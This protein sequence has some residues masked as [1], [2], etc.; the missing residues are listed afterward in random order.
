[1]PSTVRDLSELTTIDNADMFLVS[2]TSDVV[3][4]DKRISRL[5]LMGTDMVKRIGTLTTVGHLPQFHDDN[6]IKGSGIHYLDVARL[7]TAQSYTALATFSAG[8]KLG[9][10]PTTL[11]Y[12]EEGTW[13]PALQFGGA[14]N[15]LT[16]ASQGL[17][18]RFIRVNKMVT[19]WA[20]LRLSHVGS[21]V[22][23]ATVANL[24]FP[25]LNLFN[26]RPPATLAMGGMSFTG[27]I[28]AITVHN[29]TDLILQLITNGVAANLTNAAFTNSSVLYVNFCYETT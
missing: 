24:P 6:T 13:T 27:T 28:V 15:G 9:A 22:G 14:S 26:F 17:I 18:G 29:T 2:D 21:S 16:Y 12:Y 19:V 23:N 1:M 8:I 5:N 4:R 10:S 3:N 7:G 11:N 20:T 25:T